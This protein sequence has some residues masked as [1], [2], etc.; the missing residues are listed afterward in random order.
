M[1][2][3]QCFYRRNF[4][5]TQVS[6]HHSMMRKKYIYNIDGQNF[7]ISKSYMKTVS[8]RYTL[9][10]FRMEIALPKDE[11]EVKWRYMFKLIFSSS[12]DDMNL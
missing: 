9:G 8:F 7:F 5:Q 4:S 2:Q 3:V 12:K 11:F 1:L 6:K 10:K